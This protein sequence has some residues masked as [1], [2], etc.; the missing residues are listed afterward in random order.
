MTKKPKNEVVAADAMHE[1][2]G[3]A[4]GITYAVYTACDSRDVDEPEIA[5]AI[6]SA[7]NHLRVCQAAFEKLEELRMARHEGSEKPQV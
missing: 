6:R 2:L 7:F 1:H 4:V 3:A 5:A